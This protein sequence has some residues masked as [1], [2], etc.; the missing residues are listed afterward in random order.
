MKRLI[1]AIAVLCSLSTFAQNTDTNEQDVLKSKKGLTILPEEGDWARGVNA[2]PFLN[3]LGNTFNGS[4]NN[5]TSFNFLNNNQTIF[6][7]Y[8]LDEK[9]AIRGALRIGVSSVQTN[10]FVLDMAATSPEDLVE[11]TRTQNT[12]IYILSAGIEKRKG[13][14]RIQGYYG[15]EVLVGL[16]TEK[17]TYEYGNALS[18]SNPSVFYTS[19][20]DN[21]TVVQGSQRD[22]YENPGN[23]WMFGARGFIGVEYFVAPKLSLGGE[24]GWGPMLS[25]TSEGEDRIERFEIDAVE[26][27]NTPVAKSRSFNMDTDNMQGAIKVMFHF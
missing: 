4:D 5:S 3:Y 11:D 6:G 23:T 14:T 24:F 1:I 16:S 22:L 25:L 21:E 9:T 7:K 17:T 2:V 13:S 12:G 26:E 15:A 19:D 27:I 10:N 20:F 8:F 18:V